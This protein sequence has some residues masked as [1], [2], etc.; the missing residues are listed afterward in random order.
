ME[1]RSPQQPGPLGDDQPRPGIPRRHGLSVYEIS[2]ALAAEGIVLH[3]ASVGQ[4]L[5]EEGFGRLSRRHDEQASTSPAT[6]GHDTRLPRAG[7]TGFA[8]L[9]G[10]TGTQLAGLLL[11]IPDLVALDLPALVRAAGY[12][13]SCQSSVDTRP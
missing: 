2:A 6:A 8:A 11:V 7:V 12:P 4:I 10:R 9:P 1:T 13:E 3:R 5:A